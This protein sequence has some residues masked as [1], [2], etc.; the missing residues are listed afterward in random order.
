MIQIEADIKAAFKCVVLSLKSMG[1]LCVEMDDWIMV[2]T[3]TAFG[4]KY[5]THTWSPFAKA[6]KQKVRKVERNGWGGQDWPQDWRRFAARLSILKRADE[7]EVATGYLEKWRMAI[8][9]MY[10]DDLHATTKNDLSKAQQLADNVRVAGHLLLGYQSWSFGKA[11]DEGF[12]AWLQKFTDLVINTG[13][14]REPRASFTM[15]RIE[16]CLEIVNTVLDDQVATEWPVSFFQSGFGN[17]MWVSKV[18]HSFKAFMAAYRRPLQGVSTKADTNEMISPKTV[19]ESKKEGA[20]KFIK[21]NKCLHEMLSYLKRVK[22]K[23]GENTIES[24]VPFS[25]MLDV[26]DLEDVDLDISIAS[27]GGDASGRVWSVYNHR[28]RLYLV[29]AIPEQLVEVIGKRSKLPD[30]DIRNE[31]M[32][33]IAEHLVLVFALLQW[34]M[35]WKSQK[36]HLL[37]YVT[38]NTN[39]F[40][41]TEK[42]FA[43][44]EVSQDL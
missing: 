16:K 34:G 9:F 11:D 33:S 12:F 7:K 32:I 5:A 38:D 8:T 41:W 27:C 17:F 26:K 36:V 43:G 31:F 22:Q 30:G 3:R 29:V 19:K 20:R 18:H 39:S 24:T 21:D 25:S 42:G 15:D 4:W 23:Y 6:I 44:C 14:S 10:V 35:V 13:L 37:R 1:T 40:F 2:Y 28:N